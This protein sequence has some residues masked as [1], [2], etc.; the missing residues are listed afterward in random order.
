MA[1][2]GLTHDPSAVAQKILD[3][4]EGA[5]SELGLNVTRYGDQVVHPVVP[6]LYVEPAV[7]DR[8]L[9]GVPFQY[10]NTVVVSILLYHTGGQG[11][12]TI[13]KELDA[14]THQCAEF[15][16]QKSLSKNY[17]GEALGGI[18]TSGAVTRYEYAYRVLTDRLMRCN[19]LLWTGTSVTTVV[20]DLANAF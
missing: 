6:A 17:G 18:V 7:Q 19:R 14:I 10:Q 20:E 2:E 15:I 16:N 8:E 1:L 3:Y 4:Y 12:Q 13:Q 11:V 9:R 5:K